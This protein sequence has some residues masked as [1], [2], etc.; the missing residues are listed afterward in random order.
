ME[1][2]KEQCITS[3]LITEEGFEASLEDFINALLSARATPVQ[4]T[5]TQV[6]VNLPPQ[7]EA[8]PVASTSNHQP[9]GY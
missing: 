2:T 9:Q 6:V 3:S 7:A 4:P 8:V 5:T 1:L